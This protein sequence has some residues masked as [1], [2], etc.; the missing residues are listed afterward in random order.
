MEKHLKQL[1]KEYKHL[2]KMSDKI[3]NWFIETNRKYMTIEQD[4]YYLK[5]RSEYLEKW[6]KKNN[7]DAKLFKEDSSEYDAIKEEK[8]DE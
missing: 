3:Q 6:I 5:W 2:L 7:P 8:S 4:N 1:L